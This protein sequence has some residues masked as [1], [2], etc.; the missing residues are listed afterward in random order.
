MIIKLDKNIKDLKI[1]LF[2]TRKSLLADELDRRKIKY[3]VVKNIADIDKS[4]DFIFASGVY[5]IINNEYLKIPAYGIIGFH[6][7]P[8]PEGR[9]N[10]PIQWTIEN[11]RINLT[12]SAFKFIKEMD[13]G[14]IIYQYN[15]ALSSTDTLSDLEK[16]RKMG[17]QKCFSSIIDEM[18]E[19]YIVTRQQTG[20]IS[21]SP[22]RAPSDS[23]LDVNK[24]LIELW[25]KIRV[26]DNEKFPAF[27]RIHK[28]K[29]ILKYEIEK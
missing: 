22:K 28:K 29:I 4:F 13:A 2:G 12:I 21:T 16:K 15:I 18:D 17:I 1:G 26:C 20:R 6:E 19:G 25:D 3:H 24:T 10:A 9:G 11:K 23:E 27:F 7:T 8:L 5:S 14:E